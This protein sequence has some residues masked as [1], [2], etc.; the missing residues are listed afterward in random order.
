MLRSR[1]GVRERKFLLFAN[2][3]CTR[4]N[5]FDSFLGNGMTRKTFT[6]A[7]MRLMPDRIGKALRGGGTITAKMWR[8]A[9]LGE[10]TGGKI[11]LRV[12][13]DDSVTVEWDDGKTKN[14]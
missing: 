1:G 11:E 6:A 14:A 12:Y 10:P 7:E 5:Y 13:S 2:R 3:R 8:L 9:G 4:G